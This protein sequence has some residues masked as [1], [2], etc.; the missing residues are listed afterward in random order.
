MG[1]SKTGSINGLSEISREN[2]DKY[3]L[4]K[5]YPVEKQMPTSTEF[6]RI[7]SFWSKELMNRY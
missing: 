7:F 5:E 1:D 2:R 3:S 4:A 6:H